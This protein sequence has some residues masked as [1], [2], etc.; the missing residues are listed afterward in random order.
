M[1]ARLRILLVLLIL[2]PVLFG[3]EAYLFPGY[4]PRWE[5]VAL[6]FIFTAYLLSIAARPSRL[7]GVAAVLYLVVASWLQICE[8]AY[9]WNDFVESPGLSRFCPSPTL[10][11]LIPALYFVFGL[12]AH[13]MLWHPITRNYL[14]RI[15]RCERALKE[16]DANLNHHHEGSR[17][18]SALQ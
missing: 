9:Y 14:G 15:E 11:V 7:L 16:D 4:R 3:V 12:L 8:A 1:P 6:F 2:I 5:L 13:M 18:N 10:G 17:G